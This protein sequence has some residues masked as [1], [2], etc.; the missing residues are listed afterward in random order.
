MEG[1][2]MGTKRVGLA[3]VEALMENLKRDLN[4]GRSQ[5]RTTALDLSR[6]VS[7]G[8]Q[9]D[10]SAFSGVAGETNYWN[11]ACGNQLA[12][13]ALGDNQT[14]TGPAITTT[15]INVSCDQTNNDGWDI[16]T[17]SSL[18]KGT[19][20]ADYF[21]VGTSGAFY[22]K[23]KLKLADVDGTDD[24]RIGFAKDQAF[25]ATIDN[26]DDAAWI[27]VAS[28][29]I[30]TQTIVGDAANVA[31]DLT[32]GGG[33]GAGNFADAGTHTFVVQVA[34]DGSVT[35]LIDGAAPTGAVAYTFTD[36]TSV[37]P[38]FYF[39]HD[40]DLCEVIEWQTFEWGQGTAP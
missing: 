3:R 9:S 4:L 5:V 27:Q 18:Q 33:D 37:T 36:G 2:K 11:F 1:Y 10:G 12:V 20:N 14:L 38:H 35:Y 21:T 23:V 7:L 16:R 22:L 31:T 24:L 32:S 26:M 34:A 30:K 6:Q 8:L 13:V 40:T 25:D 19:L 39:L 29:D 17:K 28:G 15:G